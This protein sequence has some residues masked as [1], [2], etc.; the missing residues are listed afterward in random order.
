MLLCEGCETEVPE[1]FAGTSCCDY[2]L[3]LSELS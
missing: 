3:S 2:I 1:V